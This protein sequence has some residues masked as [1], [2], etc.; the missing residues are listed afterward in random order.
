MRKK[1][2]LLNRYSTEL[3]ASLLTVQS[4][5]KTFRPRDVLFQIEV[6]ENALQ[7]ESY[8]MPVELQSV[9]IIRLLDSLAN[10]NMAVRLKGG[11]PSYH[12]NADGFL[13]VFEHFTSPTIQLPIQKIIFIQ[14]FT[15]SYANFFEK[16][17]RDLEGC[18]DEK[19]RRLEPLLS[20][21]YSIEAQIKLVEAGIADMERKIKEAQGLKD[22]IDKHLPGLENEDGILDHLPDR[23]SWQLGYKKNIREWLLQF[24]KELRHHELHDGLKYRKDLYLGNLKEMLILQKS[25]LESL[26]AI[27]V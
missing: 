11:R 25:H 12:L 16:A 18:D 4:I 24:D 8:G 27:E 2:H 3:G 6:Y 20:R 19:V 1:Q 7:S 26:R 23:L 21:T 10:K 17:F 9:Q 22:I 15:Q 14:Y 13:F 5:M